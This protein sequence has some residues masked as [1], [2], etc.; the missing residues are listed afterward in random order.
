MLLI[1]IE[2]GSE[3]NRLLGFAMVKKNCGGCRVGV[4]SAVV[5]R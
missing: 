1:I 4:A 5:S 2:N 3:K